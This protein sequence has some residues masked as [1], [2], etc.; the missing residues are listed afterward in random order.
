M[1][2]LFYQMITNPCLDRHPPRSI[3]PAPTRDSSTGGAGSS[4]S[5]RAHSTHSVVALR[6]VLHT[7]KLAKYKQKRVQGRCV[8]CGDACSACCFEC[9]RPSQ[10][11]P[12]HAA[13]VKYGGLIVPHDCLRRHRKNPTDFPRGKAK[14]KRA[15]VE[16]NDSDV[17]EYGNMEESDQSDW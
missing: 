3:S 12:L 11:V 6:S 9:S 14:R 2:H 7:Q 4:S 10:A 5:S 15:R 1:H 16:A 13:S 8:I 17:S